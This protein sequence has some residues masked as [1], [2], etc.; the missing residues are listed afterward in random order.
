ML[1]QLLALLTSWLGHEAEETAYRTVKARTVRGV[2]RAIQELTGDTMTAE[3]WFRQGRIEA[4]HLEAPQTTPA[5]L[6]GP[7]PSLPVLTRS[8]VH[9]MR[10]DELVD[11]VQARGLDVDVAGNVKEL[12]EAIFLELGI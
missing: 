9:A 2:E 7:E 11:L 8:A 5:T 3:Q 4:G 10:R 1:T 6:P 12:R